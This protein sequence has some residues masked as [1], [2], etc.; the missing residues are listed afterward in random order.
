M[1]ASNQTGALNGWMQMLAERGILGVVF[2]VAPLLFLLWTYVMR[3]FRAVGDILSR[4]RRS[5]GALVFHPVCTLGPVAVI[6]VALCG[7][8]DH[9]FWRAETVMLV[10]A[11]FAMA[12]SAFPAPKKR[13]D[14]T[15]TEK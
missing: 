12:G 15:L 9:S 13:D 8:Y 5:F 6:A 10:A 7:F 3:A 2:F 1:F 14:D 11:I 4:S